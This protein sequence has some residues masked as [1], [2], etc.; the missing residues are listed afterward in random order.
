[1][2]VSTG[3]AQA[4]PQVIRE[5]RAAAALLALTNPFTVALFGL[6]PGTNIGYPA[7]IVGII[8]V[9]FI[10]AGVRTTLSLPPQQQR[11]RPQLALVVA[12][13]VVFGF[14][15]VN[16]IEL[17]IDSHHG[18]AL[19]TIGD[20]LIASLLIGIGRAWELVGEWD[21]GLVASIGRL[22]GH[23]PQAPVATHSHSDDSERSGYP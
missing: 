9:V 4:H 7:A 23:Q 8:G 16:G 11:R 19:N 21:T 3:R 18:G 6:V 14:Q 17:I 12:L 10:A 2:S 1:M 22:I 5:F 15:I 13:L 20:V